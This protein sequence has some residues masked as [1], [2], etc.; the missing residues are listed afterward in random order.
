MDALTA[1]KFAPE[2]M[3]A[4]L[5]PAGGDTQ[6]VG[7]IQ[8]RELEGIGGT[9]LSSQVG[10]PRQF[11][12]VLGE[13]VQDVNAKQSAASEAVNSMLSGEG[14]SLHQAMISME[15]ASIS[16]QLMVEVRNKLL[17]SYQELMRMQV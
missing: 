10:G 15:E 16:F 6:P 7:R 1:M 5:L 11:N 4:A 17:E 8:P 9:G 2:A 14:V 13:L 3:R 12:Q